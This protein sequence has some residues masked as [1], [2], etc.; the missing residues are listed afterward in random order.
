[1]YMYDEPEMH[2]Y[3]QCVYSILS[4]CSITFYC[5]CTVPLS[6]VLAFVTVPFYYANVVGLQR[7]KVLPRNLEGQ[8]DYSIY[9][10]LLTQYGMSKTHL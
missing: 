7:L 4:F 6:K 1:M 2:M 10:H 5:L 8:T 9:R 3:V